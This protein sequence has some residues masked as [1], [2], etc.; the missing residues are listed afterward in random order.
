MAAIDE[1]LRVLE[2]ENAANGKTI[3]EGVARYF[4]RASQSKYYTGH[5]PNA[6]P[7]FLL[8]LKNLVKV[9]DADETAA[10]V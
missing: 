3:P 5:F 6:Y 7:L 1:K 4:N 10:D 2:A 8:P 9:G